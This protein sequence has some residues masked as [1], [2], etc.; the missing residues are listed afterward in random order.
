M[1][2]PKS[3]N[4]Q[5]L[6]HT[7]LSFILI[8]IWTLYNFFDFY[9]SLK[10]SMSELTLYFNFI[11]GFFG[12][13]GIGIFLILLRVSFFRKKNKFKLKNNF[14][15][16]FAGIFNLNIFIIWVISIFMKII[17]ID[18]GATYFILLNLLISIFILVDIYIFKEKVETK[19]IKE[20]KI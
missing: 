19:N 18:L 6:K 5:H 3:M 20:E 15:Y 16:V 12:A 11:D 14:F 4:E 2:K 7:T 9:S 8:N 10:Y 13:I 1:F 17:D